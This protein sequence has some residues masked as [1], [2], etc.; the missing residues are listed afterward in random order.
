MPAQDFSHPDTQPDPRAPLIQQAND[1]LAA[2]DFPAA[3]KIL[4]SL[5]TQSPRNPQVLYDLGLTLEALPT[6]PA[7]APGAAALTPESC[8]RQ[9]IAA[10]PAFPLRMSP[11]ACCSP[12]PIVLSKLAPNSSP[13]PPSPASN[14]R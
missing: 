11:S 9:A 5:N 3:L 10:D 7:A 4:T 13:Q 8:Y 2:G 14:P 6:P 12:V 1:A